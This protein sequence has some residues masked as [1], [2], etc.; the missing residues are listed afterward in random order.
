[1]SIEKKKTR[2]A[3]QFGDALFVAKFLTSFLILSMYTL[4]YMKDN[5]LIHVKHVVKHLLLKETF[6]NIIKVT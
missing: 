4:N 3:T 5:G 6:Y 1:M 2:M